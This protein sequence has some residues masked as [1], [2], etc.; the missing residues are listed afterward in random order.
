VK[1]KRELEGWGAPLATLAIERRAGSGAFGNW[2]L[3]SVA[4]NG[5]LALAVYAFWEGGP[6]G[7]PRGL[8][9]WLVS[10]RP[11]EL[12]LGAIALGAVLV[13]TLV[14]TVPQAMLAI[15]RDREAGM[16][17][18]LL[19]T[20]IGPAGILWGAL[21]QV[22]VTP[23]AATVALLPLMCLSCG[24]GRVSLG[25][26]ATT[27][28]FLLLCHLFF[29]MVALC[30]AIWCRRGVATL[31]TALCLVILGGGPLLVW[32]AFGSAGGR[33]SWVALPLALN[34][35]AV[36]IDL[37][38]PQAKLFPRLMGFPLVALGSAAY[39]VFSLF[40]FRLGISGLQRR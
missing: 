28:A 33:S 3:Q 18:A 25:C 14:G 29:A 36:L 7:L 20:R 23:V 21:C 5:A 40:L 34:P 1:A 37:I 17:D 10:A 26:V 19:L 9:S 35:A 13:L 22:L 16:L 15:A 12:F 11:D 27:L 32:A 2:V 38:L 24:V 6:L 30:I 4:L 8:P 31:L 39:A